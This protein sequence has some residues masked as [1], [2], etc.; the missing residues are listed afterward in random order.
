MSPQKTD[1]PLSDPWGKHTP[2]APSQSGPLF[3]TD[4]PIMQSDGH[5]LILDNG[6]LDPLS[7]DPHRLNPSTNQCSTRRRRQPP[8]VPACFEV[9]QSMMS[10]VTDLLQSNP[11]SKI[12]RGSAA[13]DDNR[14]PVSKFSQ[15]LSHRPAQ[16]RLAWT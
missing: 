11:P 14:H 2:G 7:R 5:A 16:L 10:H 1:G 4:Q 9:G 6:A 13:Y 3:R 12:F 8:H 15:R